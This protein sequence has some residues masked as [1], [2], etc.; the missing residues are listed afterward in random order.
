M[1]RTRLQYIRAT[2]YRMKRSYGLPIDLCQQTLGQTDLQTGEKDISYMKVS[3]PRAIIQPARTSRSFVYDLAYISA[4]KDFTS[5][6][7]FDVSDRRIILDAADLPAD[8]ELDNDQ[9]IIYNNRRYDIKGFYEFEADMGFILMV[10]ET[11]GQKMVR[12]LDAVSI[13][14]LEQTVETS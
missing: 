10:R 14:S 8:W 9:F 12:L 5:G 11:K 2:L 4:N 1:S 13:L 6:G 7:F 3:I